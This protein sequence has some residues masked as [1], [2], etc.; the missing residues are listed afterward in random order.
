MVYVLLAVVL[1]SLENY[2]NFQ[3]WVILFVVSNAL[4]DWLE[5]FLGDGSR[6]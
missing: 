2:W 1:M 3:V 5:G 6:R 4:F